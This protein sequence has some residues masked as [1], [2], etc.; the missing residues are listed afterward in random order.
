MVWCLSEQLLVRA[1]AGPG[2][3]DTDISLYNG[4]SPDILKYSR[5]QQIREPKATSGCLESPFTQKEAKVSGNN[6]NLKIMG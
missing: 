1:G 6:E 3:G 5:L 4:V 2:H